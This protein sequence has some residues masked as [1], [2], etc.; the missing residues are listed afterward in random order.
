MDSYEEEIL[1]EC[2]VC[3]EDI[4]IDTF[5]DMGDTVYCEEC[6]SEFIITSTNPIMIKLL[7]EEDN[8]EY[9]DDWD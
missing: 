7:D 2:K 4:A 3:E 6:D 9:D 5:M 8:Y 1:V